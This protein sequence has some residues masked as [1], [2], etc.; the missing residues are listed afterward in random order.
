MGGLD[1]MY[2]SNVLR[3]ARKHWYLLLSGLVSTAAFCIAA[4]SFV[5]ADYQAQA[6]VLLLPAKT[7]VAGGDNPLLGIGGLQPTADTLALAM[8]D[9]GV[10]DTIFRNGAT[11]EYQVLLDPISKGPVLSVTAKNHTPQS[12][13]STLQ[14]VVA[15]L[16]K[17]LTDL[18]ARVHVPA[19]AQ[20]STMVVAQDREAKLVLKSRIRLLGGVAGLGLALTFGALVFLGSRDQQRTSTSPRRT[21]S[22]ILQAALPAEPAV[23]GKRLGRARSRRTAPSLMD[24]GHRPDGG[25]GGPD[26]DE[27]VRIFR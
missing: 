4:S 5:P 9:S 14:L 19:K 10:Q 13:M 6:S 2:F 27:T 23:N 20:L 15:E 3:T 1:S 24:R 25:S 7:G 16:P 22:R 11:G 18:Q 21:Q 8:T 12:A 26:N 17:V